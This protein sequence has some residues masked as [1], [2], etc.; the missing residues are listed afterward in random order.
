MLWVY[1][2]I[3]SGLVVV[4]SSRRNC[5]LQLGMYDPRGYKG[6]RIQGVEGNAKGADKVF[7]KQTLKSLTP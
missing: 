3:V 7:R 4:N 2:W 6:S 5:Y 1:I